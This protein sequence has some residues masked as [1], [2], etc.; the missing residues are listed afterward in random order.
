MTGYFVSGLLHI[1]Q[2]R[3]LF[4]YPTVLGQIDKFQEQV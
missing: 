2:T 4:I 3:Y 1:S